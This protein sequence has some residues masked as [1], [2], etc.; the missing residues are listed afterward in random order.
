M[1]CIE[2]KKMKKILNF[3][4]ID[5]WINVVVEECVGG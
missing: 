2:N 4:F 1:L 3:V 5:L